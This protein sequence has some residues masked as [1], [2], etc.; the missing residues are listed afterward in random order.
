MSNQKSN[1]MTIPSPD[2]R[3]NLYDAY[4]L[5]EKPRR[6]SAQHWIDITPKPTKRML[7]QKLGKPFAEIAKEMAEGK[8]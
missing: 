2:E 6:F 5:P 3:P 7:E 8:L 4:D 1:V